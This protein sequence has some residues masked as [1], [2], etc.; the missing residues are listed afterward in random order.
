MQAPTVRFA[1]PARLIVLAVLSL[2]WSRSG[3]VAQAGDEAFLTQLM[4]EAEIPGISVAFV[5]GGE[6]AWSAELGVANAETGAPVTPETVF[7]AASLTKPVVAYAV[8][9]LVE[10]GEFDLDTP[11]WSMLPYPRLEHDERSRAI[12][13]RHVLSHTTGLPNWGGDPLEMSRTPGLRWGYSGEAFVYLQRVLEDLT[14]TSLAELVRR[15]VFEPLGMTSSSL[16]WRPEYEPTAAVPH[17]LVGRPL[18]KGKPSDANAASSLHTTATDYGRFLGAVLEGRGLEGRTVVEMLSPASQVTSGG[19]SEH[20]R[21]LQ[22][23]LGWGLQNGDRLNSIWHWGDNGTFRCFVI[24]YPLQQSGV[25]YFTNSENGLAIAEEVVSRYFRDTHHSIR[26]LDYLGYDDPRFRARIDL[27]RAFLTGTA[28]GMAVLDNLRREAPETVAGPELG[29]LASYLAGQG[30]ADE[31]LAVAEL[32]VELAPGTDAEVGLAE[33]LTAVGRY[34]V[35]LARYEAVIE[36]TPSRRPSLESRV[37]WLRTGIDAGRTPVS[38]TPS[39]LAA[40]VG[41]YGPRR[42]SLEGGR[43]VYSREG[44]TTATPLRPLSR[45][46]FELEGNLTFRIRFRLDASGVPNAII[47]TYADGSEDVTPRS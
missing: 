34:E 23:G 38:L 45:E 1:F 24:A 40:Y 46:L 44:A 21:N 43:L 29:G 25:V 37:A 27:R 42:I 16:V 3:L 10:R 6:V 33:A 47:G 12:T 41:D 18:P 11:L 19:S 32:R 17:D 22:W 2:V 13:A 30:R 39:Q 36:S 4:A 9:R 14:G 7:E 26:W 20:A 31:S 8:L 28:N 15:E 5:S 35:A